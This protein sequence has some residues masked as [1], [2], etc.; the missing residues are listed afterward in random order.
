[1]SMNLPVK[2]IYLLADSQLL[3]WRG[4]DGLFL[5]SLREHITKESPKAVYVG[6]SNGDNPDFYSIF[7]VAM[8]NIGIT[9]C[10]MVRAS[11]SVDDS[12]VMDEADIILL[13]GGDVERGWNVFE[14]NGL[15]ELIVRRYFEG[16]LL[17]GVSAG[18][19]QLGSI[20]WPEG[21][22]SPE[23]LIDTFKLVPFIIGAHEEKSD[24]EQLRKAIQILDTYIS[25][26]GI[27]TGGGM[28]YHADHSIEPI[29]YPLHEFSLKDGKLARNLL[30]STVAPNVIEVL[31]VC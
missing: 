29:R 27:Q 24:W 13:A 30:L 17:M 10:E 28:I 8:E 23:N 31:E 16:A 20:G 22:P 9:D 5:N 11:F 26:I 7:R 4:E 19:V 25:G 18:A 6:A 12:T 3:F 14:Q 15:K 21:D 1:M 2:P